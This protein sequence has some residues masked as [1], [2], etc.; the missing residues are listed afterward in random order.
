MAADDTDR[1]STGDPTPA[2]AAG[3]DEVLDF[4]AP[5]VSAEVTPLADAAGG[6]GEGETTP[7]GSPD[8]AEATERRPAG[9]VSVEDLLDDLDRVTGERDTHLADLQR[10]SAEFANFR[11]QTEK[12]VGDLVHRA[13]SRLVGELL[14]VLDACDAALEHGVEGIEPVKAALLGV[15][16]REGLEVIGKAGEPFDP[17]RHEAVAHEPDGGDQGPTV[18]EVLRAG[19]ALN[20][21]VVRPAMVKVRG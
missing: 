19:Y 7:T 11:R 12:R 14:P 6:G 2:G 16:E 17:N 20:G 15:L 8:D 9:E 21:R 1:P 18:A 13:V 4:A 3:G 10:V 5:G